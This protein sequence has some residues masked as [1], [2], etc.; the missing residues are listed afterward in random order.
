MTAWEDHAAK[1]DNARVVDSQLGKVDL[2]VWEKAD[3]SFHVV[4][5]EP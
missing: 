5:F 3:P 1:C 2:W 4:H